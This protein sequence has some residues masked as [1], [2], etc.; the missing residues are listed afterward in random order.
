[1][2]D[3]FQEVV[4]GNTAGSP[5]KAGHKWTHLKP[6]EISKRLKKRGAAVSV[7]LV[8]QLLS[9]FGYRRRKLYKGHSLKDVKDRNEQF[10]NISILKNAFLNRGLPMLSI[11][12]KKKELLGN[13][14]RDG[15]HYGQRPRKVYDHDFTSLATGL[16][17]P[18]GIYDIAQNR[19]YLT[20]GTSKDTSEFVCDNIEYFWRNE[21]QYIYTEADHILL[22]CDAGGSNSAR[23]YLVKQDLYKLAQR[24]QLNIIVAHYPAYCSKWNPIEH[25]LFCHLT[26]A[27]QGVVFDDINIV[28]ELAEKATT[29][30]GLS[31]NVWINPKTYN[32]NRSVNHGFKN[33][34]RKYV[35][36]FEVLPKW[37]YAIQYAS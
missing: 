32:I 11:D 23:H 3:H 9:H 16:V 30:T 12:T 18:H 29:K 24:L 37:N 35:N 5:M 17:I 15:T 19:G 8:K 7:Y 1:M 27:W 26:H 14:Y 13:Y 34:I 33:N 28:K 22:L 10:E 6:R 4:D 20:L 31:V 25:R 21:L 2:K 36:F